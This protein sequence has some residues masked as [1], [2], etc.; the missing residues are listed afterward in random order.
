MKTEIY[1]I[2][3]RNLQS[4]VDKHAMNVRIRMNNP[5]AIHEHTD[6]MTAL[7][8]ELGYIAEYQDKLEAL[9]YV[10]KG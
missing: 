1:N 10:M 4:H 8:L 6:F 7:E 3:R 2:L 5:T 9:E